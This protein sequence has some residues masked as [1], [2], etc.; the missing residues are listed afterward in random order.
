MHKIRWPIVVAAT[1]L[2]V[3]VGTASAQPPP[4]FLEA[5][6]RLCTTRGGDFRGFAGLAYECTRFPS[7]FIDAGLQAARAV[8]GSAYKGEFADVGVVHYQCNRIG[9]GS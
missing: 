1:A 8:W 2:L 6:E 9:S 4:P 5:A 3:H 7:A